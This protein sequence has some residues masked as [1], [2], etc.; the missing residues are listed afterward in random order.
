MSTPLEQKALLALRQYS[1]FTQGDRIAVGVSGGADSVALLRFLAVLREEYRW[2]LI[3]CHIHH[4]L[5]GAEADRDEQF[6]RELAGQLGLPYTVRHIDAAALALENH[7]SVEE[8]GRNARYAFFAETAGE[9]GRIATAHT[10]D[11]TIETVLMNLIRGTGLHGLCGIPRIRGNIVRPLLDV[12]R[13][14]VEEYLALLGQPYC[15]DSTNLSDDYTRNRIRHDILPR[16]CELNPN[17]TGAMARM[18]PQLAAQW[19]LT[20]Q[21][22]ESAAQQLQGLF[23]R[24]LVRHA[25]HLFRRQRHIL[26][27]GPV[28]EEVEM[29]EDHAHLLAQLVDVDLFLRDIDAVEQDRSARRRL[30][31]VQAA[32]ERALARA[33]GAD[34]RD[35]IALPDIDGD[36]VQRADGVLFEILA[37]ILHGD[38]DI[39]CGRHGSFSF[40][41]TG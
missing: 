36:A 34:G 31:Q 40:R 35:D 38:D 27:D 24:G 37:E 4:G 26:Q 12:T 21:L 29:L 10:L 11:D 39:I 14:E 9:G 30:Q 23:R 3:V 15:T 2:E 28:R 8:A 41:N 32:Q 17:F 7:L 18:L 22:A 33:G 19:A 6:V 1:L 25:E 5:R 13:A 16:L 20:E